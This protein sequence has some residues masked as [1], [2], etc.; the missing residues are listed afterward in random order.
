MNTA[1]ATRPNVLKKDND[2]HWYSIPEN[3]VDSFIQMVEAIQNAEFM[4]DEWYEATDELND[5][6]GSYMKDNM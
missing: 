4:S 2:G 6:F 5:Q 1:L 3:M